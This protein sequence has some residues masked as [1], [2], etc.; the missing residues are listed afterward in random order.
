MY[1]RQG[2][3]CSTS[4][5]ESS[6]DESRDEESESAEEEHVDVQ[7]EKD[8]E[9]LNSS[10]ICAICERNEVQAEED[11]RYF[12]AHCKPDTHPEGCVCWGQ[13]TR[14]L[15]LPA[16]DAEVDQQCYDCGVQPTSPLVQPAVEDAPSMPLPVT[17]DEPHDT[18]QAIYDLW[19]GDLDEDIAAAASRGEIQDMEDAVYDKA[20]DNNVAVSAPLD[21]LDDFLNT[22]MPW[23]HQDD[24][25]PHH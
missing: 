2:Y 17:P 6:S 15:V 19:Y 5:D 3:T 20:P 23:L 11:R 1:K 16:V 18:D 21:E 24:Q 4:S 12:N 22:E 14:P 10:P 7:T 13:P 25:K 9:W 8:N